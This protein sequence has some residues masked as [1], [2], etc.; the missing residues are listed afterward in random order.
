MDLIIFQALPYKG[1]NYLANYYQTR[2][3]II[4]LRNTTA[5]KYVIIAIKNLLIIFTFFLFNLGTF[6]CFA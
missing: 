5:I 4:N 3:Q 6:T 1:L 2:H